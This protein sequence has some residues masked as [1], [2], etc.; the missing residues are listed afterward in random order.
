MFLHFRRKLIAFSA[1]IVKEFLI[2]AFKQT[3]AAIQISLCWCNIKLWILNISLTTWLTIFF[4]QS[5]YLIYCSIV[6]CV[7]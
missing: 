3:I 1:A 4:C 6:A 2:Q 7:C 5:D